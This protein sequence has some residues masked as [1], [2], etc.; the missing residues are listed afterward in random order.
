MNCPYCAEEINDE[1]VVCLS[2]RR[3][4]SVVK[5][6]LL[7]LASV[8]KKI[9][10]FTASPASASDGTARLQAFAALTAVALCVLFTSGYV[11]ISRAPIP[12]SDM[13]KVLAVVLPP[14]V[15]GLTAGLAWTYQSWRTYLVPAFALGM[16]NLFCIWI[17]TTSFFRAHLN[18]GLALSVFLLGQPLLFA[19]SAI[20]GNS[21]RN[22]WS[23]PKPQPPKDPIGFKFEIVA[24]KIIDLLLKLLSLLT[25]AL[26]TAK[27]AFSFFKN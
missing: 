8:E 12:N 7:R 2:C 1:A 22:R 15:L 21:L 14:F 9:E 19:I 18:W 26:G 3:D 6:L 5:P 25:A 16:F 27:G 11:F 20:V 23:P 17:V 4:L 24:N 10:E 13:S